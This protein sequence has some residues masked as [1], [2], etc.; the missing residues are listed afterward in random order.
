MLKSVAVVS[1]A[2]ASAQT[3][4]WIKIETFDAPFCAGSV[5]TTYNEQSEVVL[6]AS[7]KWV[8]GE[9]AAAL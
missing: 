4:P 1:L 5:V 6:L 7:G 8:R 2:V 3:P 9:P